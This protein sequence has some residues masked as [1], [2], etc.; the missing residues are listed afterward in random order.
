M[1]GSHASTAVASLLSEKDWQGQVCQL[2]ELYGWDWLHVRAGR[3]NHGWR[4][5]TSG[6]LASGWVDVFAVH[7]VKQRSVF[8]EL[9]T[10]VGRLRPDQKAVH[11]LLRA[12]GCEV[13]VLR[14]SDLPAL[15]DVLGA[16]TAGGGDRMPG[17]PAEAPGVGAIETRGL[18]ADSLRPR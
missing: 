3:T 14:P 9:K 7:A 12:A 8:I 1:R 13:H 6:T 11:D 17:Y 18:E 2:L 5:A 16:P 15:L 10:E 4:V